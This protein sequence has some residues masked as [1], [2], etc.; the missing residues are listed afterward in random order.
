MNSMI[1]GV[2]RHPIVAGALATIIGG[3]TLHYFLYAG[4]TEPEN[5]PTTRIVEQADP[6]V[7]RERIEL[8]NSAS[9]EICNG[10]HTI[11]V[12]FHGAVGRL[13]DSLTLRSSSLEENQIIS[14]GGGPAVLSPDCRIALLNFRHYDGERYIAVMQQSE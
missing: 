8:H 14:T 2:L 4:G 5:E 9:A 11:S 7:Q 6:R 10:R 1:Q 12:S 3:V 13:P